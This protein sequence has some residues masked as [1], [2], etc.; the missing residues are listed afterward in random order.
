MKPTIS[1]CVI[2]RTVEETIDLGQYFKHFD[3]VLIQ[4]NGGDAP[5]DFGNV[6][7]FTDYTWQDNFAQARNKL[8]DHIGSEYWMWIDTDDI[9]EGIENLP[10]VLRMMHKEKLDAV[11]FP[12][13]YSRN[14]QHELDA[15]QWRERVLRTGAKWKWRGA[16]H[17]TT[18]HPGTP[19]MV[20]SEDIIVKHRPKTEAEL[21]A[22]SVR[23]H[24]ILLKEYKRRNPDP[25]IIY[26]LASSHMHFA[27]WVEAGN[28]FREYI[29]VSGW[30]EEKYRAWCNIA[31]I[32]LK[33]EE[34]EDC[35]YACYQA[36][37]LLPDYPDAYWLLC[38]AYYGQDA[39][40]K[41]IEWLKVGLN[42]P[43]PETLSLISPNKRVVAMGTGALS[44]MKLGRPKEAHEM[45]ALALDMSPDNSYINELAPL[46]EYSFHEDTAIEYI[47][48]LLQFF[49]SYKGDPVKLLQ[50]LPPAIVA[51]PN[52]L[53]LRQ[54]YLPSLK[55]HDKSVV[56]FCPPTGQI[57]GADTLAEGMG[58]S[59]E[60]VVYLSRELARLGYEVTVFNERDEEYE[61][62]D[63]WTV[64]YK[65]WTMMNPND[66]YNTMIVWR[67]PEYAKV[68]KARKMYC[69]L[70][71]AI[72]EARLLEA[73]HIDKFFV[74]SDYQ[75]SLYPN[76][77]DDKF[78]II[79]N[80]IVETQYV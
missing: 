78:E 9:V 52:L 31:T 61:D 63:S 57:W 12:Y 23:N 44:L 10:A 72:D 76:V 18:V 64:S 1:L 5:K 62:S 49:K 28:L 21:E 37:D 59:E 79:S 48:F 60:A 13:E 47:T 65:P 45:L 40:T 56:F 15:Y 11:F 20:K 14:A 42:K 19:N 29:N 67:A 7:Y 35:I 16:V 34:Y 30:D 36:L 46:V 2:S 33:L 8:A 73:D 26:Y 41:V 32:H 77:A 53:P 39:D 51:H 4:I 17:E 74:K 66:Q 70:H 25:R 69:D 71:D 75:R 6:K 27:E 80:G 68:F 24:A 38:Q 50:I 3:E 22:S 58:G 55:W 54:R 43:E